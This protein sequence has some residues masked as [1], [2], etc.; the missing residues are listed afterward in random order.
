MYFGDKIKSLNLSQKIGTIVS[1]AYAKSTLFLQGIVSKLINS[2][3]LASIKTVALNTVQTIG[4]IISKAYAVSSA[5]LG[6]V[7]SKLG[8][9][10]MFL[11]AK[12]IA[13]GIAQK[14]GAVISKVFGIALTAAFG[15]IGWIILGIGALVAAIYGLYKVF[16]KKNAS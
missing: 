4:T 1:N 9:T 16:S 5:F 8:I 2:T 10:T 6:G 13:L 12:T 3:A 15:P 14:I 11:T 7:F